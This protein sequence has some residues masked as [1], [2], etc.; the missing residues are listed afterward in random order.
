M[1]FHRSVGPA[2]IPEH[3][4]YSRV[5]TKEEAQG[6]ELVRNRYSAEQ[7]GKVL[8]TAVARRPKV[9]PAPAAS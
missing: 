4:H 9:R 6:F 8:R 1:P 3:E 7:V 2:R 5:L